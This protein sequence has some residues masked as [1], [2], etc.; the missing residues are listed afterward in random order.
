MLKIAI[1]VLLVVSA[2]PALREHF[3]EEGTPGHAFLVV[4]VPSGDIVRVDDPDTCNRELIALGTGRQYLAVLAALETGELNPEATVACDSTCW[5]KGTHGESSLVNALAWG[6]TTYA[7]RIPS[8]DPAIAS[9]ARAVGLNADGISLRAWTRFWRRADRAQLKV[10]TRTLTNLLAVAGTTV[11]SP[12][13]LARALHD[14][15]SSTRAFVGESADGAWVAGVTTLPGGRRW[16]FAL[17][18]R[19]ATPSLA[20][21][22]CAEMIQVTKRAFRRSTK[23]RGGGPWR[24]IGD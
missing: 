9:A 20:G 17:F 4:D 3:P 22:R 6:C 10:R 1:S 16:A 13:G 11:S 21:A 24:E 14:G 15:R 23:E 18:L 2:P 8:A 19:G 7:D 12:R 5:A